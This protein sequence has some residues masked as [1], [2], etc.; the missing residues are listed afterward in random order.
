MI[1]KKKKNPLK[2]PK[3][4]IYSK[5]TIKMRKNPIEI[6]KMILIYASKLHDS[7]PK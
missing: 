7:H 1:K 6:S 2:P 3:R 4:Q 5:K